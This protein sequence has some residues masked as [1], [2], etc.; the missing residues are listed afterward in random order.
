VTSGLSIDIAVAAAAADAFSDAA[1][2][3]AREA[4]GPLVALDPGAPGALRGRRYEYVGDDDPRR[5]LVERST[6]DLEGLRLRDVP[7]LDPAAVRDRITSDWI[8]SL[9]DAAIL[10][11]APERAVMEATAGAGLV[12][13]P[14]APVARLRVPALSLRPLIA[15]IDA[16]ATRLAR[17]PEQAVFRA[18]A[19]VATDGQGRALHPEV[20]R[21]AA[22]E[23]QELLALEARPRDVAEQRR[24]DAL[25][26]DE[27]RRGRYA[28]AFALAARRLVG[29]GAVVAPVLYRAFEAVAGLDKAPFR[30]GP[31]EHL[32]PE[33]LAAMAIQFYRTLTEPDHVTTFL[34]LTFPIKNSSGLRTNVATEAADAGELLMLAQLRRLLG[35]LAELGLTRVR[36][37]CLTDGI[38]YSRYLG[39]YDRLQAV[40][41]RENVRQ[42]RD[43]LGLAGRVLIVDADPLLRR[44]P[45]FDAVLGHAHATLAAAEAADEAVRR[46]LLSLTRSFL[47]HIHVGDTCDPTL[48]ARIVDAGLRGRQLDSVRESAE[49][50]RLWVKAA[51]DARWYAAHL[52]T[53]AAYGGVTQLLEDDV[54]RAT[55]HPKP[56]QYAPAPVN[57]RDF[58]D[59]PYHRKPFLRAGANPLNLDAYIGANLWADPGRRF[60]DVYVGA[61]RSPFLGVQL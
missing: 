21:R 26:R 23:L 15:A 27:R 14:P 17:D 19:L 37:A 58:N 29:R 53:M 59:L 28:R 20:A 54:I 30:R 46:K 45:G 11:S 1:A 55:V 31:S 12:H 38:V 52:V 9:I 57:A 36:F 22:A 47:F 7:D 49:Q 2:R 16:D 24:H 33:L 13:P 32:T 3:R 5:P 18:S 41:Y 40:Y 60:V 6:E 35:F 44:L 50:T 4:L 48:L 56:G 10:Q 34:L 39:P 25:T 43:A 51:E 42:F 61:D 8:V